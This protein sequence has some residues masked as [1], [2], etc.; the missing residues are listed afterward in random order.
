MMKIPKP[1]NERERLKALASYSIMDSLSE[2]EY[3]SITQLAAYICET[4]I[5]LVSLVDHDRQWFKSKVGL[6]V[7]QTPREISF[8]QY[9]IMN[10]DLFEVNDALDDETF[11][12]NPL[13]TGDPNIRFYAGTP[14]KDSN[15]FN[16]GSLCVID[17]KSKTLNQEQRNALR[18]LGDQV[19]VLLQMRKNN[20]DL[21]ATQKEY[22]N[23]I[24]YSVDLVCII[25]VSHCFIKVNPA[26][27]RA[28]GYLIGELE[29]K[30]ISDYIHPDDLEKTFFEVDKLSNGEISISFE[31]R[32]KCKNG[33]YIILSWNASTDFET[34]NLYCIARDV[35][36]DKQQQQNLITALFELKKNNEELDQF[37]YVVSH[38]L[39]APLRAI[40]NLA[41]WILEDMPEMSEDISK[42]FT[43]LRGRVQ[44]MENLINGVLDYSRIG[45]TKIEK[46]TVDIQSTLKSVV[47]SIVPS[48]GF[49]VHIGENMPT[50]H[51][52]KILLYQ[53]FSNLIG[54][55]VK[56]ND[57]PL[58]IISCLYKSVP[59]FHQFSISDN[60][61]GIATQYHEKVFGIFQTIEARDKLESTGIGLSIVKKI[62]EEKGGNIYI[63]SEENQGANFVFRI[64]K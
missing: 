30:A 59:K 3:D 36:N 2:K 21:A 53:I 12:D 29:G 51:S 16:L 63:E 26:I 47:E 6:D 10:D 24:D 22:Y 64:P 48:E 27:T 52:E 62:V 1:A 54:N 56:Y 5:A 4:P 45:R 11:F 57:K 33:D 61:P 35:T 41:E 9:T 19:V 13:V 49:Q 25:S 43:M 46:E 32:F 14:L 40:N 44:R 50:I 60:G 28:L 34:G 18:L 38:D 39:K 31:N 42:N 15:G 37:A 58:G 23:F 20:F 8:C 17:T 55:A 7:S